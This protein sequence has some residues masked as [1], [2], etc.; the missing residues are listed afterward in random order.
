MRL[1]APAEPGQ[2]L[3]AMPG[4]GTNVPIWLLGSSLYSA[5]VAAHLGYPFAFASHFAPAML[6]QALQ[7]YSARFR[8]NGQPGALTMR[9]SD[10]RVSPP[11]SVWY[12]S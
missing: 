6:K 5:Q 1:L 8:P 12:S 2:R 9:S 4:A 11:A 7:I 10:A 3:I